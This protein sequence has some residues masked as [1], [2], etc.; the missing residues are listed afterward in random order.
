MNPYPSAMLVRQA[1]SL[2]PAVT[3]AH[4]LEEAPGFAAWARRHISPRY[5]DAHWRKIHGAGM[6]FAIGLTGLVSFWPNPEVVFLFVALY[7]APIV[8]NTVFHV[9]T[10]I[11]YRSYSPGVVT[12]LLLHPALF[13]YLLSLFQTAGL[14]SARAALAAILIGVMIHA[15]DLASTT[16]FLN[17]RLRTALR[18]FAALSLFGFGARAGAQQGRPMQQP[19]PPLPMMVIQMQPG[20]THLTPMT[21]GE[22]TLA[23]WLSV[24]AASVSLRYRHVENFLGATSASNV[25]HQIAFRGALH[26]DPEGKF[27]IHAGLYSGNSFTGGWD[28]TGP[29]TGAAQSNLYLKR[30][31]FAAKPVRGVEAQYGGLDFNRGESSEI[32]SYDYD[33]YLVGERVRISRPHEIFFDEISA[34]FGYVG[35]LNRPNVFRRLRGLS[36]SNYHQFL[37][38]KQAGRRVRVSADYTSESGV[39]TLR[40]A[41]T[42]RAP[43]LRLADV[44]HFEQYQRAG[45]HA[46]YGISA[47]GEKKVAGRISLGAGYAQLDRPGLYSD[48]FGAGK[49]LFWNTHLTLNP[50]W[51]LMALAT[52][53]LAGPGGSAPRTRFDLILGYNLAQ[54]LRPAGVF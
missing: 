29:G 49:R 54:Q 52:Y 44:V 18:T 24:D 19:E 9:A 31:Y 33:G 36:R 13:W 22:G 14:F 30:L 17:F 48:R 41:L 47:Y 38:A 27:S 2:A 45:D 12:A 35:D 46:G 43:E 37:V 8:C 23:R 7:L 34:T 15:L 51:S 28:N 26:L 3:A 50:E 39:D 16:F 32:T 5:T 6:L 53:A 10:S 21:P 11:V 4:F 42:L 25:Q 1:V 40:Q 20:D